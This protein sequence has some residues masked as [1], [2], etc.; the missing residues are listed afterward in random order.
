MKG[1]ET[2]EARNIA[3]RAVMKDIPWTEAPPDLQARFE[4]MMKR[5]ETKRQGAFEKAQS[6][7]VLPQRALLRPASELIQC[8]VRI[9]HETHSAYIKFYYPEGMPIDSQDGILLRFQ[10]DVGMTRK[11]HVG[12]DGIGS[13]GVPEVFAAFPEELALIMKECQGESVLNLVVREG[14]GV[15]SKKSLDPLRNHCRRAGAWL[16]KFQELTQTDKPYLP[17]IDAFVQYVDVR[18]SR[19][20]KREVLCDRGFHEKIRTYIRKTLSDEKDEKTL[21]CG[22]HADFGLANMIASEHRLWVLDFSMYQM[23]PPVHD[24]SY[25]S[26]RLDCLKDKPFMT[27]STLVALQNA[28]FE[29]YAK[30]TLQD[31]PLFRA[32]SLRHKINRL[33][34]LSIME[35]LSWIKKTYQTQQLR[36]CI[37]EVKRIVSQG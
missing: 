13:Y 16:K 1:D 7:A 33:V 14:Q 24:L 2:K 25:F 22:V 4:R 8:Q 29:G 30:G 20:E 18:L 11:L 10:R 23:G 15:R 9:D 35:H 17:D 6:Y 28:F 34:D 19:L 37:K 3:R 5:L 12:L 26:F 27:R 32:Y 21:I 36:N 31:S